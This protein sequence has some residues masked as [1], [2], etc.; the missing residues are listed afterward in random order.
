MR[1]PAKNKNN[2]RQYEV[3]LIYGN[4]LPLKLTVKPYYKDLILNSYTKTK[5][6]ANKGLKEQYEIQY[7][8]LDTED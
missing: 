8:K 3:L 6:V 7:I 1:I 2:E 5:P 4:K